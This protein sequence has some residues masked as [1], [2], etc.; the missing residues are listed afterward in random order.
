MKARSSQD[1]LLDYTEALSISEKCGIS[2]TD[3]LRQCIQFLTDLGSLQYFDTNGLRDKVVINPQ[4]IVDVISC[5]ISV[6]ESLITEGKLYHKDIVKIWSKYDQS[7]HNWILKLT[8]EFD[9]TFPVPKEQ[10]NIVPCLLSETEPEIQWD[11]TVYDELDTASQKIKTLTAVYSFSHIPAGLFNRV[12]VRLYEY[13]DNSSIWKTGSLLRKNNHMA[14]L[15][16]TESSAIELRVQGVKPENVAYLV[17]EVIDTLIK[18]SQSFKT[19]K[20]EYSFPCMECVNELSQDPYLFQSSLLKKAYDRKAPYL[21]C[22][23]S[24]HVVSIEDM[25]SILPIDGLSSDID[26]GL[27]NSLR[28][29]KAMKTSLKYDIAFWYCQADVDKYEPARSINPLQVLQEIK[30]NSYTVWHPKNPKSEKLDQV[31]VAIKQSKLVIMGVSDEFSQDPNCMY[32]F[33]LVKNITKR[34]YLLVEFGHSG[35]HKWLE[36]SRFASVCTDLRVVMQDPNRYN[37]KIVEVFENVERQIKDAKV[38]IKK[39]QKSP[40]V[41]IS[42]CW[43][44]SLDAISRG[45]K[46]TKTGV[47]WLD[48]RSLASF[49]AQHGIEAWLDVQELSSSTTLFSEITKGINKCSL[50][51]ACLSDEYANSQNCKLEFR[52]AHTSLKVPI[53]KAV[54]GIGNEW[55]KKEISF[56]GGSYPEINFQYEN[57]GEQA[58]KYT[59]YVSIFFKATVQSQ[60]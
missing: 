15:K 22:H 37:S 51:V 16:K 48:P 36:D 47:G 49:F 40:D 5:I 17:H 1:S 32:L 4:W 34:N 54:V 35:A 3:E 7:L 2:E 12:Q 55:R 25:L 57:L 11:T 26:L 14:L 29:L 43:Q 42:Y 13:S 10:Y 59:A 23:S 30:N 38:A 46:P 21:Q 52:F 8:E 33:D 50:V 39:D 6:K 9:L 56:I 44:N 41:F 18:V 58:F 60:S 45:T 24:F 31:T 20:Y 28:D 27:G 53:I 19:V